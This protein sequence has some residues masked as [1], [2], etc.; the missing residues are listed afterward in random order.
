MTFLGC[1][2]Q[3]FGQNGN[4]NVS[5]GI[6][7]AWVLQNTVY[8]SLN[9]ENDSGEVRLSYPQICHLKNTKVQDSINKS[10]IKILGISPTM[11]S[12]NCNGQFVW[13]RFRITYN[14]NYILSIFYEIHYEPFG[15]AVLG[16]EFT[17]M[18]FNLR[19]GKYIDLNDVTTKGFDLAARK[20]IYASIKN[21]PGSTLKDIVLT[22]NFN[23]TKGGITIAYKKDL[24]SPLEYQEFLP[25]SKFKMYINAIDKIIK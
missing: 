10:I 8:Y 16:H 20:S 1:F 14:S 15:G 6:D 4:E 11:V 24:N 18:N 22:D 7:S 23:F 17:W 19:T 21:E 13:S 12:E 5:D 25:F 3:C 2:D 9:D